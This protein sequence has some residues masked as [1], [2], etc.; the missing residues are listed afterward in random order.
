MQI[1]LAVHH[2]KVRLVEDIVIFVEIREYTQK[3]KDFPEYFGFDNL[4]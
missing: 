3:R 4:D 2:F 1:R